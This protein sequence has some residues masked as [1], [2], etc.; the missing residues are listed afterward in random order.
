MKTAGNVATWTMILFLY[1][2]L[3]LQNIIYSTFSRNQFH[4]QIF[5]KYKL[6]INF[7][8]VTQLSFYNNNYDSK[9]SV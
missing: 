7:N 5:F 8:Y 2:T 4:I 1:S 3:F 6:L 9:I